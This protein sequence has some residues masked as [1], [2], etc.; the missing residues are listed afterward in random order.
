M[1][2]QASA[3]DSSPSR[4][5]SPA[6]AIAQ[7]NSGQKNGRV[8]TPA[9]ASLAIPHELHGEARK[10]PITT[11]AHCDGGRVGIPRGTDRGRAAMLPHPST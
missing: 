7:M 1:P 5:S 11:S 4:T 8:M 6:P 9:A 2:D 10:A 3:G